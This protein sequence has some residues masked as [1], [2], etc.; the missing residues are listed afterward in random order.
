MSQLTRTVGA[1]LGL[2]SMA[3]SVMFSATPA[4]FASTGTL[5]VNLSVTVTETFTFSVSGTSPAD[6]ATANLAS[7]Y[8]DTLNTQDFGSIS[9]GT[10]D[11]PIVTSFTVISNNSKGYDIFIDGAAGPGCATI[12]C[13]GAN[14]MPDK[15]PAYATS[16]TVGTALAA[17]NGLAFRIPLAGFSATGATRPTAPFGTDDVTKLYTGIPL[18]SSTLFGKTGI[19]AQLGDTFGVEFGLAVP[20]FQ[21]TGTYTT[22]PIVFSAINKP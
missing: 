7:S 5:N 11:T 22:N 12:M 15:T 18:T 9:A 3:T 1:H 2:L 17:G 4:A 19:T 14:S 6:T 10:I 20:S 21:A 16:A 13:S 8:V